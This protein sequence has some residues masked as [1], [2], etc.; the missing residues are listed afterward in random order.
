VRLTR[1]PPPLRSENYLGNMFAWQALS[2]LWCGGTRVV[3]RSEAVL[4]IHVVDSPA[5]SVSVGGLSEQE[6]RA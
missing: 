1:G 6:V 2:V 4:M 3:R 5:L